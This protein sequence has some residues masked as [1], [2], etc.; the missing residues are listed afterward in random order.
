MTTGTTDRNADRIW[1]AMRE[2]GPVNKG[3]GSLQVRVPLLAER[4]GLSAPTIRGYLKEWVAA[5]YATHPNGER[6]VVRLTSR[7]T[8]APRIQH[9]HRM[10]GCVFVHHP[11]EDVYTVLD[12]RSGGRGRPPVLTRHR[13]QDADG[14]RLSEAEMGLTGPLPAPIDAP[15]SAARTV[16]AIRGFADPPSGGPDDEALAAIELD[17]VLSDRFDLPLPAGE[18]PLLKA[19]A[20]D[21]ARARLYDDAAPERVLGRLS[22]ARKRVGRIAAGELHLVDA[23][24]ARVAPRSDAV[25]TSAAPRFRRAALVATARG[26]RWDG[27]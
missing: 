10:Q 15:A 18:Y 7:H 2:L 1:S 27:C 26:S 24:G 5:G 16:A 8:R 11:D 4:V 25:A 21:A 13:R 9:H 20:C 6:G 17:A 23:A 14:D 22:S 19:A 3:G 12:Y